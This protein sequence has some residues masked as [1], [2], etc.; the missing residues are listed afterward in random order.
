MNSPNRG[1]EVWKKWKE[2]H[3]NQKINPR[4]EKMEKIKQFL[5]E[6]KIELECLMEDIKQYRFSLFILFY[7]ILSGVGAYNLA[8]LLAICY[9]V[10]LLENIN[11]K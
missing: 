5:R 7:L 6:A 10:R 1:K 11:K 2:K 4:G 9:I 8:N 3:Q